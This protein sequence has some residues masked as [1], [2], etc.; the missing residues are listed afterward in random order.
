MPWTQHKKKKKTKNNQPAL[1]QPFFCFIFILVEK[2]TAYG[3]AGWYYKKVL[4]Y[5]PALTTIDTIIR[6]ILW[7]SLK[8][9]LQK[10]F[11][12]LNKRIYLQ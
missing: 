10:C 11:I 8:C 1:N 7:K 12:T 4:N 9:Y 5:K 3:R 2:F 6:T